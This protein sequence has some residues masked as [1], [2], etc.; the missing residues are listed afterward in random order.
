MPSLDFD[1]LADAQRRTAQALQRL[2]VQLRKGGVAGSG[3]E[4]GTPIVRPRQLTAVAR[5]VTAS[6]GNELRRLIRPSLNRQRS[7][8]PEI[9]TS[10]SFSRRPTV[11]FPAARSAS[12]TDR[13][14][15]RD[16]NAGE[17][18]RTTALAVRGL[19]DAL[20]RNTEAIVRNGLSPAA[21]G[22]L[23]SGLA[24]GLARR[25][26]FGNL[27]KGGF[28]LV[29]LVLKIA[30]LFRE[31]KG[32]ART[33]SPF[34]FPPSLSLE[35]ANTDNVLNGFPR[36]TRGQ[37]GQVRLIEEQATPAQ[38]QVLVNVSA[39]DSQSFLDRSQDIASALRDAMLH[40]HPV[41]DVIG[42]V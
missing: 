12:G 8:T 33:F 15:Q 16:E 11:L 25:G 38:P 9:Q 7:Q 36:T 26:G 10:P 24:A 3:G 17:V 23:V 4:T 13:R 5:P 1:N 14:G 2:L 18:L 30:G 20:R 39:M 35:V 29:P 32:E 31:K 34:D 19:G 27:F 42:E 6:F 40:M 37:T 28:G 22:S 21:G 41:N